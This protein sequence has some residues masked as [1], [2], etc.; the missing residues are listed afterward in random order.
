MSICH[1]WIQYVR[2]CFSICQYVSVNS[3]RAVFLGISD[4][5]YIL[6]P[7]ITKEL[8]RSTNQE[9]WIDDVAKVDDE[10]REVWNNVE[11][12]A[13]KNRRPN[14]WMGIRRT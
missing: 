2:Y 7:K 9:W 3:P 11:A 13:Y 8:G 1:V 5:L 12:I 4:F 14:I 10:K 6:S